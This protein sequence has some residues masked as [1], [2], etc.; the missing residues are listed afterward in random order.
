[1]LNANH[2]VYFSTRS[3]LEF[4]LLGGNLVEDVRTNKIY[5]LVYL[6]S[7]THWQCRAAGS[8]V[9]KGVEVP[10]M[11]EMR[12]FQPMG[13]DIDKWNFVE[14]EK[15]HMWCNAPKIEDPRFQENFLKMLFRVLK[16]GTSKKVSTTGGPHDR[17]A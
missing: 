8:Q 6:Y 7:Q 11:S 16:H 10:D 15:D 2:K 9:F 5:R 14:N 3:A 4:Y 12:A 1:M 13:N 17:M